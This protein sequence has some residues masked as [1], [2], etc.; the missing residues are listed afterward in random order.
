MILVPATM[1]ASSTDTLAGQ[2][3]VLVRLER[4][5]VSTVT[6]AG[7]VTVEVA[8]PTS[9]AATTGAWHAYLQ[10]LPGATNC[11]QTSTTASCTFTADRSSVS[12]VDVAVELE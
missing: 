7:D 1:P 2:T 6:T 5:S 3:D 11:Q 8:S 10:S 12:V 9:G 4:G